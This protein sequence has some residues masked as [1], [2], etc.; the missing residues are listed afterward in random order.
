[1]IRAG[2]GPPRFEWRSVMLDVAR[3][4][5]GPRDVERF[6]DLIARY[7]FN[8]LHL[9]LTDDQGWRIEITSWPR[10]AD[11]GGRTAVGGGAGGF[12]TQQEYVDLCGYAAERGV[13]VV[14][15]LDMPSHVNAALVA[16]PELAPPG[17]TPEPYTG[18]DVGFSTLDTES[19]TVRR[20][21]ADVIREIA[22]LTPGP[23]LHFGGDEANVTPEEEY[24]RFVTRV[25][26]LVQAQGKTPIGWE[27]IATAP[28]PPGTIVQH[29]KDAGLA[30]EALRQRARLIMSPARRAY[31]D[32]K[33]DASTRLG[34]TWAGYVSVRDAYEWDP[35]ALVDG[36]T[37]EDVL[38]V[39]AALWSETLETLTDVEEMAFPRLLAIAEVA[40]SGAGRDWDDLRTRIAAEGSELDRLGVSFFR[41]PEIAWL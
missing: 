4:F 14:P 40:W 7:R 18:T 6:V 3:H 31:L 19:E 39:E 33:Y 23:Y 29:W 25:C 8:G 16:Y 12:Y 28:L 10:L 24:R 11:V 21:T 9:H 13:T 30:R 34:T 27:E 41:S 5:F 1:M 20:F 35:P 32:Q 37:D 17:V 2:D 22:A 15:E 26:E 38:G 36:A